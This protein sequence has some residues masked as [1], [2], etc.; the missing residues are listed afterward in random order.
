MQYSFRDYHLLQLLDFYDSRDRLP[1]DLAAQKYFRINKACGSKDRRY[2]LESAYQLVRWRM[3]VDAHLSGSKTWEKRYNLISNKTVESLQEDSLLKDCE[4]YS[5]PEDIFDLLVSAYG[6]EESIK[7]ASISNSRA[8]LTVRVNTIKRT[9]EDVLER[10]KSSYDVE[11]CKSAPLAINW[12]ERV[13]FNELELFKEGAFEVQDEGSQLLAS[14][15]EILPGQHF[16]DYCSGSGGKTL[17]IA[18]QMLGRGQIYLHDIRTSVLAD[19]KKRLKKAGVQNFQTVEPGD[20]KLKKM[21]FKMDWVLVDAPCSGTGTLRRNPDMKWRLNIDRINDLVELQGEVFDNAL[22]FVKKG[23]HIVYATCSILKE[24][25]QLQRDYFL[26]KYNL[27]QV[28][29]MA[30]MP[31]PGGMDAFYGVVFEVV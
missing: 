24:E 23:G 11:C 6:L 17:A 10:L 21:K 14:L 7:I 2:I 29:E 12:N 22:K 15:V 16:L 1:L 19:A 5:F 28:N 26:T 31:S 25:N 18:P 27:K 3:L 8:P 9:Y 30:I 4:R 20:K 13:N